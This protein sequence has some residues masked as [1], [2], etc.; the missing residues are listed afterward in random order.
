M[1]DDGGGGEVEAAPLVE[2]DEDEDAADAAEEDAAEDEAGGAG[3]EPARERGRGI[4]PLR[5][6]MRCA[7]LIATDSSGVLM[8]CVGGVWVGVGVG[9]WDV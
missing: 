7:A 3:P 9:A 2:E 5:P 8:S 4:A 1:G 6:H